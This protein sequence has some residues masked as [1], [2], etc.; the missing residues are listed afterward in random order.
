MLFSYR[1]SFS[2]SDDRVL[3]LL[4]MHAGVE[5]V[6]TKADIIRALESGKVALPKITTAV[7]ATGLVF[8]SQFLRFFA[9]SLF[10]RQC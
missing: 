2:I 8:F 9:F 5:V 3:L 1:Q 4:Y 10:R 6:A 7:V